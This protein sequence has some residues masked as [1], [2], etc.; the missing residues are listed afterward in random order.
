MVFKLSDD[1]SPEECGRFL[2]RPRPGAAPRGLE[3]GA[4]EALVFTRAVS[5][6]VWVVSF[7]GA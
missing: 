2:T 7:D 3:E 5:S 1:E 6:R 4:D